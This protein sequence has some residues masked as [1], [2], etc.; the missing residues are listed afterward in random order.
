MQLPILFLVPLIDIRDVPKS[1]GWD[2][3][4]IGHITC[5]YCLVGFWTEFFS[6]GLFSFCLVRIMNKILF[7]RS[8]KRS[9][10]RSV[11]PAS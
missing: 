11:L 3:Y 4:L 9:C 5:A 10:T 1:L 7:D 2:R 6:F 8:S